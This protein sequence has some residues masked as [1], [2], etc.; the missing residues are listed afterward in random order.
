MKL[1]YNVI[2]LFYNLY[3]VFLVKVIV[4]FY[5]VKMI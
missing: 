1:F 3:V 5:N 2:Y 4:G